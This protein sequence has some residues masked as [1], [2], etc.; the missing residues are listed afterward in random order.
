MAWL[1]LQYIRKLKNLKYKKIFYKSKQKLD[2][3]NQKKVYDYIKKLN[4]ML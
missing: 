3:T 2:L 1:V 4:P